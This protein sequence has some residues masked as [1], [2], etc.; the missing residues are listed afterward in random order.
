MRLGKSINLSSLAD[1]SLKILLKERISC[2]LRYSIDVVLYSRVLRENTEIY[3]W[4][5]T[6]RLSKSYVLR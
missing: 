6:Y 4:L 2:D 5:I 1:I 3:I